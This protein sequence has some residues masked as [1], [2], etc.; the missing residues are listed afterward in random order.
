MIERA[1]AER[2][3]TQ[4][5]LFTRT[6]A[7]AA[8]HDPQGPPAPARPGRPPARRAI[9]SSGRGAGALA[10][11]AGDGGLPRRRRGR[12]A[13]HGG[14]DA[15][16]SPRSR[17]LTPIEVMALREGPVRTQ[18]AGPGA[19]HHQPS[20]R[21]RDP[22]GRRPDHERGAHVARDRIPRA[23]RG[24]ARRAGWWRW[25]PQCASGRPRT[26]GCGG[27]WRSDAAVAATGC[28]VLESV[29]AERAA[30]G[31]DG[32]LAGEGDPAGARRRRTAPAPGPDGAATQRRVRLPGRLR[33]PRGAGPGGGRGQGPRR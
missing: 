3:S 27:C 15:R 12:L 9:R 6:Q 28:S 8:G 32:E 24:R 33:L 29:L 30:P 11:S 2:A 21:G 4:L 5:G 26:G 13:S 22:G 14:M 31:P 10:P 7:R 19:P 16:T 1:I 20:G 25:S 17:R 18:L 23:G